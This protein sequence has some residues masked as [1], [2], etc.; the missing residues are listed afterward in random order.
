MIIIYDH[1]YDIVSILDI[2]EDK[3]F[4]NFVNFYKNELPKI[5]KNFEKVINVEILHEHNS[6]NYEVKHKNFENTTWMSLYY[7]KF[8]NFNNFKKQ[9]KM[10]E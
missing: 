5:N 8:D 9:S 4:D 3:E 6:I 7:V 1:D 2:I 10:N